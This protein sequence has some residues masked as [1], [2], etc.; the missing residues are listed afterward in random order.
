MALQ[1]PVASL[2]VS[3]DGADL[4]WALKPGDN[5]DEIVNGKWLRARVRRRGGGALCPPALFFHDWSD[6]R[7]ETTNAAVYLFHPT[8]SSV[9]LQKNTRVYQHV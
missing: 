6:S 9:K 1:E 7:V 2:S 3:V 4:D 5:F 8:V